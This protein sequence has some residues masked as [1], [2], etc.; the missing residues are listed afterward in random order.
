[1]SDVDSFQIV[2]GKGLEHLPKKN[3]FNNPFGWREELAIPQPGP[4]FQVDYVVKI[5]ANRKNDNDEITIE[6]D[7]LSH[8]GLNNRSSDRIRF[9]IFSISCIG[10]R[11]DSFLFH[12]ITYENYRKTI[13]SRSL[14]Q[15]IQ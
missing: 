4:N 8:S 11:N 3:E 7:G 14:Y 5:G 1:M 10:V 9:P 6:Y 13:Y 15:T 12:L 2:I